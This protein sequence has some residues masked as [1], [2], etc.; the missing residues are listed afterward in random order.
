MK[1]EIFDE[2]VR[3]GSFEETNLIKKR[4]IPKNYYDL[5]VALFWLTLIALPSTIYCI[6]FF[7]NGT[8]LYRIGIIAFIIAG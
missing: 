2:F 7:V 1:D 4:Y 5:Y 3:T 8:W 6:I